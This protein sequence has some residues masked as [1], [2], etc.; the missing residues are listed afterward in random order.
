MCVS[1]KSPSVM[2]STLITIYETHVS[3]VRAAYTIERPAANLE[4]E[5]KF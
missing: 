5:K 4:V 3:V 1:P 2:I